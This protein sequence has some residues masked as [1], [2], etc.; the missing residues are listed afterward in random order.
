MIYTLKSVFLNQCLM[1]LGWSWVRRA[2][3]EICSSEGD[4]LMSKYC[5]KT[6]SWSS[7]IRVRRRR[8]LAA[9]AAIESLPP[10]RSSSVESTSLRSEADEA[11]WDGGG[12]K[13]DG[14]VGFTTG[15]RSAVCCC[16]CWAAA[17]AAIAAA[18]SGFWLNIS[19]SNSWLSSPLPL[20]CPPLDVEFV[21]CCCCCCCCLKNWSRGC[22]G[23]EDESTER[24]F[25]MWVCVCG[26]GGVVV[27]GCF[28]SNDSVENGCRL[29]GCDLA[30][31]VDS[32]LL[33]LLLFRR[34]V[35][36]RMCLSNMSLKRFS[37]AHPPLFFVYV[38]S[39]LPSVDCTNFDAFRC[40][41]L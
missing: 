26:G 41:N 25:V 36:L 10:T 29:I 19:G 8:I 4:L 20:F 5:L 12:A 17:A 14:V 27:V 28:L 23:E 31:F 22:D 37:V 11:C 32:R 21:V 40:S 6:L 33:V 1:T 3:S 38:S 34:L 9:A 39:F 2:I 13:D 35:D 30:R 16:C 15:S 18:A 24:S 7:V